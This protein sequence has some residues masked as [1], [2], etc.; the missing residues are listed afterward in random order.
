VNGALA[1]IATVG[2]LN[3]ILR[4][5]LGLRYHSPSAFVPRLLVGAIVVN[6]AL[7]WV[8]FAIDVN[9]ALA[10]SIGNATPPNWNTLHGSGVRHCGVA[11]VA[12]DA[13]AT[14]LD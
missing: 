4:P 3:G 1:L 9:N 11:F 6:T 2:A 13:D 10:A 7:W 8:Q 5:H 14:G 12:A